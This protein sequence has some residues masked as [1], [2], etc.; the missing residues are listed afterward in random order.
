MAKKKLKARLP[1][2]IAG[3]KVPKALRKGPLGQFL[4]SPAGQAMIVDGLVQAGRALVKADGRPG[5]ALKAFAGSNLQPKGKPGKRHK[6]GKLGVAELAGGG[7]L[8]VAL[9]AAAKAFVEH[10]QQGP[11]PERRGGQD[12]DTVP[13]GERGEEVRSFTRKTSP[14]SVAQAH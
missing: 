5:E 8:A 4:G 13:V 14:S 3:V 11:P 1:K 6:G 9:Q 12:A 2:R 7:A 10:L